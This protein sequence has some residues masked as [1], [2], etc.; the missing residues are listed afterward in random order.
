MSDRSVNKGINKTYQWTWYVWLVVQQRGQQRQLRQTGTGCTENWIASTTKDCTASSS[1]KGDTGVLHT[2]YV[3]TEESKRNQQMNGWVLKI[4]QG[5]RKDS[6]LESDHG[7][8]HAGGIDYSTGHPSSKQ[9][10]GNSLYFAGRSCRAVRVEQISTAAKNG[11]WGKPEE[12]A[13]TDGEQR[14]Q[15]TVPAWSGRGYGVV[16]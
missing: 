1:S 8:V 15:W 5:I 6:T 12:N 16:L 7:S 14:L 2:Q 13:R 10:N 4:C 11:R 9:R 3:C